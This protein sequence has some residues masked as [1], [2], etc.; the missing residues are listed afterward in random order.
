LKSAGINVAEKYIKMT[1]IPIIY[2][3]QKTNTP[4]STPSDVNI[5]TYPDLINTIRKLLNEISEAIKKLVSRE[6]DA[7][8]SVANILA[9]FDLVRKDI[10]NFL[11][12]KE[13]SKNL[14]SFETAIGVLN[15]YV[16]GYYEN[17]ELV[18]EKLEVLKRILEA[19]IKIL[20]P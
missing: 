19:I 8:N 6:S 4:I 20:L 3:Q 13:A 11:R 12:E 9:C 7:R 15:H 16:E 1:S 18:K 2:V 17:E 10:E 14:K 5:I